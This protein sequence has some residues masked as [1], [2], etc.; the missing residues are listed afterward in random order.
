V[1]RI[2]VSVLTLAMSSVPL[3]CSNGDAAT[4][5]D[6]LGT[7]DA[8]G[9]AA[10]AGGGSSGSDGGGGGGMDGGNS[11]GIALSGV[12][13][14][15]TGAPVSGLAFSAGSQKG[16]TDAKGTFTYDSGSTVTF[17]LGAYGFGAAPGAAVLTPYQLAA[18]ATCDDTDALIR[19]V[20]VLQALDGDAMDQNGITLPAAPTAS[21]QSPLSTASEADVAS[22][23]SALAAGHTVRSKTAGLRS[24]ITAFDGEAWTAKTTDTFDLTTA[25]LR[26]QGVATDG[27]SWFFSGRTGLERTDDTFGTQKKNALAIPPALLAAGSD[28]IGD[29]DLWNGM[30]YAPI[31][32]KNSTSPKVVL[33]DPSSFSSGTVFDIPANVQT[34]GVPWIAVDG[35][36][37]VAY[38]A[39]WDPTP[40]LH[41]FALSTMTYTRD[42]ALSRTLGRIQG[43]KVY[44]G[45]LYVSMDDA[46][47]SIVKVHLSSGTVI[48]LFQIGDSALEEEGIVIRAMPDGTLLHTPY[49]TA[50]RTASELRHHANTRAPLRWTACK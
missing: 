21:S 38:L 26:G 4:G 50:S 27:T 43:A 22:F 45:Q 17:T 8:G 19:L 13:L 3:A 48:D 31:E 9:G 24:F 37:G 18:S 16:V 10:E 15:A 46:M 7:S 23:V 35:P 5:G 2:T 39:E 32:D 34:Q 6:G 28:H 29:I 41:V 49:V 47:K 1:N 14:Y 42:L 12:L 11:M 40:V 36:R 25:L 30:L 33:Y 44:K 20:S